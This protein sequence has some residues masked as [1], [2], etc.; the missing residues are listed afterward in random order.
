MHAVFVYFDTELKFAHFSIH[1]IWKDE[2][3][4]WK[5]E[6]VICIK[7]YT[8]ERRCYLVYDVVYFYYSYKRIHMLIEFP[9]DDLF[10]IRNWNWRTPNS[11]IHISG[12]VYKRISYSFYIVFIEGKLER[13]SA[14]AKAPNPLSSY[15]MYPKRVCM[16]KLFETLFVVNSLKLLIVLS[17]EWLRVGL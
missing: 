16:L 2:A 7:H 11:Y 4:L 5:T 3:L 14:F 17:F 1:E 8:A 6:S 15:Q 10:A 9:E 12:P 13:W